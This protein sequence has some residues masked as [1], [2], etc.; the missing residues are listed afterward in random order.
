[1]E[2]RPP[3]RLIHE[4]PQ[5]VN[6]HD[7]QMTILTRGRGK[8]AALYIEIILTAQPGADSQGW[9]KGL[10]LSSRLLKVCKIGFDRR[11]T[12]RKQQQLLLLRVQTDDRPTFPRQNPGSHC[13]VLHQLLNFKLPKIEKNENDE[14]YQNKLQTTNL[15]IERRRDHTEASTYFTI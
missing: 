9:L 8:L 5:T 11:L 15:F 6:E 2:A 3:S 13:L 1:M 4:S 14:R 7:R 12:I 10:P